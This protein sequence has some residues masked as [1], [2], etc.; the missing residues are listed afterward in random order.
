MSPRASGVDD[1]TLRVPAR[2]HYAVVDRTARL[3]EAARM[4][5]VAAFEALVQPHLGPLYRLAV[6]MVGPEEARD[7][8]Q[9]T[10]VSAWRQ[11]HQVKQPDR[12]QSWLRS[13]VMNRARNV[14]R[15]RR[16]HP[17]LS[18]DLGA[19]HADRLFHE[20]I[21]G[22]AGHWDLD[23]ALARLRPD[24]RA[25]IVLRYLADLP[26]REVATTLGIREGTAKSRLHAAL[27]S[28]RRQF[29]GDPL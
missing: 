1:P 21:D 24:E 2:G 28:V 20:P 12:L 16:R 3:V 27:Q 4:G 26:I 22:L 7:V 29:A 11:L 9:E 23:D 14:L 5:N 15:A 25:V 18:F 17:A 19:G 10:L 6:A 13:I 8:V